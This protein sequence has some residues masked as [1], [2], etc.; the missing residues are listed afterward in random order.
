MID[1]ICASTAAVTGL[2]ALTALYGSDSA[3]ASDQRVQ[4][5]AAAMIDPE[6][7]NLGR[8]NPSNKLDTIHKLASASGLAIT[9]T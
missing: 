6:R 9:L 3:V 7:G 8:I 4:D 5:F 2:Q 1:F